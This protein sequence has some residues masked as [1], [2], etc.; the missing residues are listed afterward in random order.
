MISETG[1]RTAECRRPPTGLDSTVG[2]FGYL[3]L[4]L[5]VLFFGALMAADPSTLRLLTREDHSVE[6]LTAIWFLLAGPLLFITAS[7]ERNLLRRCVYILGGVAMVFAAGE[8]ISW[9]QRIIGYATPDFLIDKN[10]QGEFNVH[11]AAGG[12]FSRVYRNGTLI[13][14]MVTSAAFFC[15]K[16]RLLGIPLPSIPL[17]LGF[18]ML[19]S[20]Q[21]LGDAG[22]FSDFIVSKEKGLLLLFLIFSLISS[23]VRLSIAPAATLALV[24]A[25]S[26]VNYYSANYGSTD[27]KPSEIREYLFGIGCL[28][29][30]LELAL[31]Q[32]RLP[33]ISRVLFAGSKMLGGQT[34]FLLITC[35]AMIAASIGLTFFQYVSAAAQTTAIEEAYR[36]VAAGEPVVRSNFDVYLVEEELIYA[37]EPCAPADIEPRFSLHVYPVDTNDLSEVHKRFGFEHLNFSIGRYNHARFGGKC[38]VVKPLPDFKI[39][40]IRTGQYIPGRGGIWAA[41]FAVGV[42]EG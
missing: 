37:K 21:L 4:C 2:T 9:G 11:N 42:V 8:E 39:K 22:Q 13:L 16:D 18:L 26:Y 12:L 23:Q 35:S 28:F 32:R 29:Y 38:L 24:L 31:A 20:F 25:L 19:L 15:R 30:S 7:A 27:G 6:Y 41:E 34:P 14:C 1:Q 17:M 3:C 40:N 36:S 5:H 33:A 10:R